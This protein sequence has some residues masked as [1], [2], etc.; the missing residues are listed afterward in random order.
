M[1]HY[2]GCCVSFPSHNP[3]FLSISGTSISTGLFMRGPI[4]HF[5]DQAPVKEQIPPSALTVVI[6]NPRCKIIKDRL[7]EV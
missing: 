2:K 3:N 5:I 1:V 7:I 4:R 6:R